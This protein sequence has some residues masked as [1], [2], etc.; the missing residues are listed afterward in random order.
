M[1]DVRTGQDCDGG[2][3]SPGSLTAPHTPS[4]STALEAQPPCCFKAPLPV[5]RAS[6]LSHSTAPTCPWLPGAWA[7]LSRGGGGESGAGGP[8][9]VGPSP[10]TAKFRE[11]FAAAPGVGQEDSFLSR[12]RTS[13]PIFLQPSDGCSS[14]RCSL[15]LT[16]GSGLG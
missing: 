6:W 15:R 2:S 5:H 16:V 1:T 9:R 3:G 7:H 8:R 12:S 13:S 4:S 14:C 11:G 10:A